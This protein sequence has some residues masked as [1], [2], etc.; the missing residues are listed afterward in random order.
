VLQPHDE[1]RAAFH[2]GHGPNDHGN[3][4]FVID[5]SEFGMSEGRNYRRASRMGNI[6][7]YGEC[8]WKAHYIQARGHHPPTTH[9]EKAPDDSDRESYE[10]QSRPKNV[11]PG[12]R[13]VHI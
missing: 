9:S 12:N 8:H 7:A 5:V 4:K 13:H 1:L 3:A 2:S 10:Q 6:G 11:K